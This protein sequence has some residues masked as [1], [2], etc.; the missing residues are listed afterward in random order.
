MHSYEMTIIQTFL[1]RSN[2]GCFGPLQSFGGNK[3][4]FQATPSVQ[5]LLK[6]KI[7]TYHTFRLAHTYTCV[8]IQTG[9]CLDK[10][11]HKC[12]KH[13]MGSIQEVSASKLQVG[14][15]RADN[16]FTSPI[17]LMG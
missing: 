17:D 8:C 12:E 14:E 4:L 6:Y 2:S 1:S 13:S 10:R 9:K 5:N 11:T 15:E 16:S 3:N 7:S